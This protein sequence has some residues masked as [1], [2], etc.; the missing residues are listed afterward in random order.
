MDELDKVQN[1]VARIVTGGK[2]LVSINN[3]YKEIGWESLENR[4]RKH[5]LVMFYKMVNHLTP[6][7]LSELVP[8]S[9][10][11]N[12]S[13]NLRNTS[14]IHNVFAHAKYHY[15]SFFPSAIREWNNLPVEVQCAASVASFNYMLN[16]N[17]IT[18]P[19]YYYFGERKLQIL[20][21]RL[22]LNCSSLNSDLFSKSMVNSPLCTCGSV[23]NAEH[24]LLKCHKYDNFRNILFTSLPL[25]PNLTLNILLC[26]D[27]NVS[28]ETNILILNAVHT[29]IRNF[30]H[31]I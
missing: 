19:K 24:F 30:R 10:G 6:T 4:R 17:M 31:F 12:A 16:R 2:Q 11:D 8:L 9:V 5:K 7:Y 14:H 26:G 27:I 3:L 22:R 20:H 28:Y 25:L 21:T 1:E 18:I 13:Y 29:Y 23:E 15:N